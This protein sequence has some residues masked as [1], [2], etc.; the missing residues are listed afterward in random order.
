MR[1]KLC[2][3][4]V[5][6]LTENS[7]LQNK[8]LMSDEAHFYLH[9]TVNKQNFD[10]GELQ[11]FTNS[12][13]APLLTQKLPYGGLFGPEETLDTTSLRMKT[14]KPSKSHLNVTQR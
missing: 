12:T 1:L 7:D 6:I 11:V 10:T 13:H 4:F 2:R 9:G 3:Q 8:L 14:E 5:G